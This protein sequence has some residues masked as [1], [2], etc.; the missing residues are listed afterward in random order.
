MEASRTV[1]KDNLRLD[2]E[3]LGP[4]VKGSIE[5]KPLTVFIG[6]N[7]SGKSYTAMFLYALYNSFTRKYY[8]YTWRE[9]IDSSYKN[10]RN[11]K[12][13]RDYYSFIYDMLYR[14]LNEDVYEGL[15]T[16]FGNLDLVNVNS[17][18]MKV[19]I[20]TKGIKYSIS[21][22]KG[23]GKGEP[24]INIEMPEKDVFISLL[25][26]KDKSLQ[27]IRRGRRPKKDKVIALEAVSKSM[28]VLSGRFYYMPASRSGLIQAHRTISSVI[29]TTFSRLSF[30]GMP[31]LTGVIADF[32]ATLISIPD[33]IIYNRYMDDIYKKESKKFR[34]NIKKAI[35]FLN[36]SILKGSIYLSDKEELMYKSNASKLNIPVV[37]TASGIAEL[38]PLSLYLEY[39]IR[40]NDLLILEE[41]ESHLHPELQRQIARLLAML[42]N[43]GVR[44]LITTHSDYLLHQINILLLLSRLSEED[45]KRLGYM[46]DE[47]LNPDDVGAYLFKY[48]KGEQGYIIKELPTV[49]KETDEPGIPEDDLTEVAFT[50][51]KEISKIA[52]RLEEYK[53]RK[54][55]E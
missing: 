39:I 20:S 49:D 44:V 22:K 16:V 36:N 27:I 41:P 48:D 32:I 46:E 35:K 23:K 19:S 1:S 54:D 21:L 30:Q 52:Y 28:F 45:R 13:R 17:N 11:L 38:A 8:D 29:V 6:P 33:R 14:S 55:A 15:T 7:S 12:T 31:K 10:I 9:D 50:M 4:I 34:K 47:Y 24:H 40:P 2:I 53:G 18:S 43:R 5:I 25:E 37:R 26:E 51:G 42:V 3:W